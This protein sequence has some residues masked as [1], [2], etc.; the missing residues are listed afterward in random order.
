MRSVGIVLAVVGLIVVAAAVVNHFAI[1]F[2]KT[3]SHA[4]LI[5]GAVGGVVLV[6]GVVMSM[7]SSARAA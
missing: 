4:S 6:I 2:M 1:H 5:I 3:T 7:M